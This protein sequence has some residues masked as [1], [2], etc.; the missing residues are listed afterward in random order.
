MEYAIVGIVA[1][2]GSLLSFMSGFGLGTLLLPAFLLFFP[3]DVAVLGTAVVHMANN[4][5]KLVLVGKHANKAML[6]RFGITS[7]IGAL[8]GASLIGFIPKS[9]LWSY[10][11][12][13]YSFESTLLSCVFGCLVVFFAFY[14]LQEEKNK[15]N[16]PNHWLPWGGLISGFFGGL[17]GHQGA[18][19]SAFL[20]R[21]DLTKNEYMGTRVV[22]ACL[23]DVTRISVYVA[24]L[25]K[26]SSTMQIQTSLL[27]VASIAAFVGAY[28][29]MRWMQ[30][31]ESAFINRFIAVSMLL[32]GVAMIA[33]LV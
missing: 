11:L 28:F 29:G 12:L 10:S 31:S 19:R 6:W 25:Q 18:L 16:L 22:L 13:G 9:T 21:T 4:L 27:V 5:F 3:A 32:F 30:K 8:L 7:V 17:S 20:L 33:G 2:L 23:V 24:V 15:S 14:E 1:C 26:A